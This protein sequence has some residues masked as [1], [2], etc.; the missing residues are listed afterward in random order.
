MA[1]SLPRSGMG[2]QLKNPQDLTQRLNYFD[3]YVNLEWNSV[4]DGSNV[5]SI[6]NVLDLFDNKQIR[7]FLFLTGGS[8]LDLAQ[9]KQRIK[10]S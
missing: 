7:N 9:C 10:I 5:L 1:C 4:F 8:F 2:T 3:I 6:D